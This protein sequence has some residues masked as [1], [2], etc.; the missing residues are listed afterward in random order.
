MSLA[1]PVSLSRTKIGLR[2]MPCCSIN[3][4]GTFRHTQPLSTSSPL[5][6]YPHWR[7]DCFPQLPFSRPYSPP[8]KCCQ[9]SICCRSNLIFKRL[10]SSSK[11]CAA[12]LLLSRNSASL[13]P[14]VLLTFKPCKVSWLTLNQSELI[15]SLSFVNS[16][17]TIFSI[18]PAG[19]LSQVPPS[20]SL[21]GPTLL[22]RPF[23][24]NLRPGL[25]FKTCT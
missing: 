10:S 13:L 1:A 25:I 22:V 6:N 14:S 5:V 21:L 11:W 9:C 4:A 23:L 18:S 17:L 19:P 3:Y 24:K 12:S 8:W 16:L 15:L 2:P 20:H 7:H